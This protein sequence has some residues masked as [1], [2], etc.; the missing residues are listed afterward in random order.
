MAYYFGFPGRF[1]LKGGAELRASRSTGHASLTLFVQLPYVDL[2]HQSHTCVPHLSRWTFMFEAHHEA[3]CSSVQCAWS[4]WTLLANYCTACLLRT[5]CFSNISV[6]Q[7]D[8][9]AE[10]PS[11]NSL[12]CSNKHLARKRFFDFH[13]C[14]SCSINHLGRT[15]LL[16]VFYIIH[17]CSKH[18]TAPERTNP[19]RQFWGVHGA[20]PCSAASK[21]P[22]HRRLGVGGG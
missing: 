13:M 1:W 6:H 7:A 9:G 20:G 2:S 22:A 4:I 19:R 3:S 21:S 15:R 12:S 17:I 8:Y 14:S 18:L 16:F 5:D 10:R 11:P